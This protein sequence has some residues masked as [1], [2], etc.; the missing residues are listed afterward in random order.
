MKTLRFT[1]EDELDTIGLGTWKSDSGKVEDAVISA[2]KSGYKHI[3]C[4]AVYGNEAEIGKAFQKAFKENIISRENLWVTSKL[5]NNAHKS[6]DVI[7][8][9]KQTLKDLQLD[10]LDLYLIHWP[11]A[12]RPDLEGFPQQNEDFLSLEEVPII[13]TWEAML[14]AKKLG[15]VKHLGVSNFSVPKLKDLIAKTDDAPE[16]NQVE[17]HPFLH[18]DELLKFCHTNNIHLTAYSPLGSGDRSSEMKA[19]DEPS[20]L[21][22]EVVKSIASQHD[23]TPA[24]ILI[25]F[26][27]HRH[28]AVI[29]KST[30]PKRIKENLDSAKVVLTDEDMQQIKTLDKHYRYVNGKFFE[31]SDGKYSNIFDE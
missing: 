10:Y 18:Q 8:A 12:F 16:M 29:P 21:D 6:E 5:W 17:L 26:H 25:A 2:L 31:T 9:L 14:E 4:A 1:N 23:A 11:V 19:D 28:T 22:N 27:L 7:P 3:D 24:Q 20:L 30:N 13:E 15:L